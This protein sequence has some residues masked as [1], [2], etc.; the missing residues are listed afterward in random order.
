MQVVGG[1][2]LAQSQ[3]AWRSPSCKAG[4]CDQGYP[5][6]LALAALRGCG[7]ATIRNDSGAELVSQRDTLIA[8]SIPAD[9]AGEFHLANATV[10]TATVC[11]A[12]LG[13]VRAGGMNRSV[14]IALHR[15]RV[16]PFVCLFAV[17]GIL[18]AGW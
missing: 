7:V 3:L 14:I 8:L 16:Q 2:D 11:R 12:A 15:C 17:L 10:T 9:A 18:A 1:T 13:S 5:L 6:S 4:V